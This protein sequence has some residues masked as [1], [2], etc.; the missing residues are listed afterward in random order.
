MSASRV[1]IFLKRLGISISHISCKIIHIR[2]IVSEFRNLLD[3]LVDLF[4]SCFLLRRWLCSE[5]CCHNSCCC[6]LIHTDAVFLEL[7]HY[8]GSD[9]CR[10][11]CINTLAIVPCQSLFQLFHGH[12]LLFIYK[13]ADCIQG[14]CHVGNTKSLRTCEVINSASFLNGFTTFQA[15]IHH[16]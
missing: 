8:N 7:L 2:D 5:S 3:H 4:E 15:V 1:H 10:R 13:L 12:L 6:L 16:T 11:L 14:I 9:I